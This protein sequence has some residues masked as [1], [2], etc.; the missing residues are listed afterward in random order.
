VVDV[1]GEMAF[2]EKP[3]IFRGRGGEGR[4][5]MFSFLVQQIPRNVIVGHARSNFDVA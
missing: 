3:S 1:G 2:S 4:K 5:N